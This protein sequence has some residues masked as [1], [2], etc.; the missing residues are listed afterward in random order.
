MVS[1]G[2]TRHLE[3][4]LVTYNPVMIR[5]EN[6]LGEFW[7]NIDPFDSGGQFCDR[8][9]HYRSAV[10]YRDKKELETAVKTKE[11][12]EKKL[13]SVAQIHTM[14]SP[15]KIFYPAEEEHQDYYKKVPPINMLT[16]LK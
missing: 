2:N 8:G 6:L 13:V 3:A 9:K 1:Q 15:R 12:I 11:A 14:I 5:F 16:N 7:R 4:I 10:Y